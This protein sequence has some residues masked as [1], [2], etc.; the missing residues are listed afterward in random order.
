MVVFIFLGDNYLKRSY[1]LDRP[2]IRVAFTA[3]TDKPMLY[4]IYIAGGHLGGG[5]GAGNDGSDEGRRR[6]AVASAATAA[7]GVALE[8]RR[9]SAGGS[10][11]AAHYYLE[12]STTY[13]V[14][15]SAPQKCSA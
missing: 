8:K 10:G 9:H 1:M 12:R 6:R 14:K 7:A 13:C 5:G 4:Q 11:L 2:T 15:N 3:S